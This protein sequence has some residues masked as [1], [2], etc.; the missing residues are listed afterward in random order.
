VSTAPFKI[1][2]EDDDLLA[3]NK[4]AWWVVHRG[5]ASDALVIVDKLKAYLHRE[6]VHPLHRLDRQTSGVLL[7]A[8]T[9]DIARTMQEQFNTGQICKTYLA[10]VRGAC[11]EK[12]I[13]DSPV[14]KN[15]GGVRVPAQT[16]FVRLG[17]FNTEPR[18]VSLVHAYPGTGRF[19]QIRRHLKHISH[20]IIGDSNYGK[21]ALNRAFR[22][23][24]GLDRLA[25]HARTIT[26][27][28]PV[29]AQTITINAPIPT[30][31]LEPFERMGIVIN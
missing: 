27:Q 21:G 15:E 2:F 23:R 17:A 10:L 25:L 28:H 8:Q 18:K 5:L 9:S 29:T 7:F 19:H 13:I 12:G 30:D 6:T 4:P 22:E 11:P 14:P 24:Y 26:F 1:L 20:P 3:I 31:L 16:E